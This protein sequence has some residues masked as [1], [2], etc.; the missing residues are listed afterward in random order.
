MII[1][2]SQTPQPRDWQARQVPVPGPGQVLVRARAVSLSNADV[3]LL[4]DSSDPA[5]GGGTEYLAG[6]EFAGEVTALGP[7][8]DNAARGVAPG[9][10]GFCHRFS[11]PDRAAGKP[12]MGKATADHLGKQPARRVNPDK[13][14]LGDGDNDGVCQR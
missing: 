14:V 8:A 5:T 7:G 13:N 2:R 9:K 4:A 1:L 10:T 3:H 11:L 6:H 12:S